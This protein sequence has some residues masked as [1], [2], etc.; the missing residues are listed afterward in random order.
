MKGYQ[1]KIEL[2]NSKPLI[3]RRVLIPADITFRR[4]HDTIQ[5]SMGWFDAHLYEFEFKEEKLRITNDEESFEEYKF[6]KKRYKNNL[7]T[8]EELEDDPF[9]ITK[10]ILETAVKLPQT[11]KIDGYIEKYKNINYVYDF[12]DYWEHNIKFE[13]IIDNYEF[14]YP[15]IVEGNGACPPEDVGG[16]SGYKDFLKIWNNPKDPEYE[17]NKTWGESQHYRP[18]DIYFYNNLLKSC[19]KIK[20][21]K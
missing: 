3:W 10:R 16:I 12:G 17:D 6:Y 4:L 13:K 18:F 20:K 15:K 8:A 21:V 9:G 11:V 7:I 5:L 1:I 19:L 2:I 14:G